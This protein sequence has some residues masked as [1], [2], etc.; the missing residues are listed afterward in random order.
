MRRF[1]YTAFSFTESELKKQIEEY[2]KSKGFALDCIS[3]GGAIAFR[4]V[5]EKMI[6][7]TV[8]RI[9]EKTVYI[10]VQSDIDIDKSL[11]LVIFLTKRGFLVNRDMEYKG[12]PIECTGEKL[13]EYFADVI[14]RKRK[15]ELAIVYLSRMGNGYGYGC[16]IDEYALAK[17]LH[18]IAHVLV[19]ADDTQR[20]MKKLLKERKTD[21]WLPYQGRVGIYFP[22][23]EYNILCD[24]S[25]SSERFDAARFIVLN[26]TEAATQAADPGR[27][28]FDKLLVE[29]LRERPAEVK[30][31]V[32]D[33]RLTARIEQLENEK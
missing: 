33:D 14:A 10:D 1:T 5:K 2:A 13:T 20:V 29:Q 3:C 6:I 17:R 25:T 26:I 9:R 22:N 11:E 12:D 18:G 7:E 28:T 31:V 8:F 19:E 16:E 24:Q 23:G 32:V 27:L 15:P 4:L 21:K 30:S